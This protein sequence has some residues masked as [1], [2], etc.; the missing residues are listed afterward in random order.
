M[1]HAKGSLIAGQL[2]KFF[3]RADS[4]GLSEQKRLEGLITRYKSMIP[5]IESTMAKID[6]YTK[7]YAF[8]GEVKKVRIIFV[9]LLNDPSDRFYHLL[10]CFICIAYHFSDKL[11]SVLI[12]GQPE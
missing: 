3:F 12:S 9:N 5:V 10:R 7:S 4:E 6:I 2:T 11:L 1:G 8:R